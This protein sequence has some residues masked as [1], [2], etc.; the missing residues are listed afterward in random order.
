MRTQKSVSEGRKPFTPPAGPDET[1][2]VRQALAKAEENAACA[3]S[4]RTREDRDYYERMS[5]KWLNVAQGW[6]VIADVDKAH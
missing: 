6:R 1:P 3:R 2:E 4:A 5:R